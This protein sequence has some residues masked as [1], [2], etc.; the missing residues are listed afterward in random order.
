MKS[1]LPQLYADNLAEPNSHPAVESRQRARQVSLVLR[2]LAEEI[3]A[4]LSAAACC[5]YILDW[6]RQ[7]LVPSTFWAAPG[8][9]TSFTRQSLGNSIA[10]LAVEAWNQKL[11]D[12]ARRG[13]VRIDQIAGDPRLQ[14][15]AETFPHQNALACPF[16]LPG[17]DSLLGVILVV[18]KQNADTFSAADEQKLVDFSNRFDLALAVQNLELFQEKQ[19]WD[20]EL[21]I[22]NQINHTLASAAHPMDLET[23]CR[24]ILEMPYLKDLFQFDAAEICLWDEATQ[25]LTSV[26][27][28]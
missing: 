18:D 4:S 3:T 17:S 1:A 15:L 6:A 12:H 24:L 27:R 26:V 9:H 21:N 10:G 7:E 20:Q 16:T 13:L 25:T 2:T 8:V 19:R 22:I 5:I 11:P 28:A 23:A 14:S